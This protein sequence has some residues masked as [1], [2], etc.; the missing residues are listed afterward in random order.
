MLAFALA[1][2]S[3][4]QNIPHYPGYKLVWQEEFSTEGV[5]DPKNW[6]YERG[7]VRNKEAQWYQPQNARVEDGRLIIEARKE[8]VKNPNFVEGDDNWMKNREFAEYTSASITTQGIHSWLYGRWEMKGK[9]D[10]RLG[11]WPAWW[12]VGTARRWPG[13]GEIDMMEFYRGVLLA[14]VA[15]AADDQW[16]SAWD[17]VKLP[18]EEVA[19]KAGFASADAWAAEDHIW[20]MDWDKDWIRLYVDGALLNEIDLSKTVNASA[21]KQNP[22]REPHVMRINL[23]VGATGGD[24]SG[25]KFPARLEVDWV[26][27]YQKSN[28]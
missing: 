17:D 27:V 20:R 9:I 12:T 23:A 13:S 1:L 21:D 25:T 2:M 8:R 28:D 15:W 22:M 10:I 6:G 18:I 19:K 3:T 26:R 16:G 11:L 5:P 24:P 4:P 7:F 14:N